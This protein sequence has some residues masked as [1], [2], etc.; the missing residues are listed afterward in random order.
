[1][2]S[3]REALR[4]VGVCVLALLLKSTIDAISGNSSEDA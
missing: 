4:G 2:A 3:L 1:M